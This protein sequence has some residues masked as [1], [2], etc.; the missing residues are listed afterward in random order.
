MDLYTDT[1]GVKLPIDLEADITGAVSASLVIQ[2]PNG[3]VSE[4]SAL[5][6]DYV[7]GYIE[8]ATQEGDLALRG[9]YKIQAVVVFA[10]SKL[11]SAVETFEVGAAIR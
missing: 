10:T 6:T 11:R 3:S 7:N 4:F 1:Y 5:I 2:R 8:Y 9:T